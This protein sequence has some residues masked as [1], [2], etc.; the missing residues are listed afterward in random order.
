[1]ESRALILKY[2]SW[3]GSDSEEECMTAS[4]EA[5]ATP[6]TDAFV[7]IHCTLCEI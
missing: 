6:V 4:T 5:C 7:H 2:C 1:M 3:V